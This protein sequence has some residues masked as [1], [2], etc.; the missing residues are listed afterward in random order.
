MKDTVF[1][2]CDDCNQYMM[3][4]SLEVAKDKLEGR[5]FCYICGADAKDIHQVKED[6]GLTKNYWILDDKEEQISLIKDYEFEKV[7]CPNCGTISD[8][9]E[10]RETIIWGACQFYMLHTKKY[11]NVEYNCLHCKVLMDLLF[12]C[13]EDLQKGRFDFNKTKKWLD[14]DEGISN[15]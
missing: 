2:K 12:Y 4:N 11:V 9:K 10:L 5:F 3:V 13:D 7:K 15:L 14:A 6:I 8:N 1:L